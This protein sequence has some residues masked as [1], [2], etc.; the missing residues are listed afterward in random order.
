MLGV[1]V[2]DGSKGILAALLL[3][4]GR[5]AVACADRGALFFERS[6]TRRGRYNPRVAGPF[7]ST[8]LPSG[9]LI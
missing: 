2:G 8:V 5:T 3:S 9:S 7:S 4:L 6:E 1:A